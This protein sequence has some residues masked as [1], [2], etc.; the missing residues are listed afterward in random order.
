MT[1]TGKVEFTISPGLLRRLASKDEEKKAPS[2]PLR[3]PPLP[4]RSVSRLPRSAMD[5]IRKDLEL[6]NALVGANKVGDLLLKREEAEVDKVNA[7]AQEMIDQ[8]YQVR[9]R[10]VPCEA[11][12]EACSKCYEGGDVFGC[13]GAVDAYAK[14][15]GEA[16]RVA[17]MET[18]S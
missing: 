2:A 18:S 4:S 12:R 7:Y 9:E 16:W 13:R 17:Q 5:A 11:E 10:P 15:A 1:S 3:P 14:C 8:G 6:R